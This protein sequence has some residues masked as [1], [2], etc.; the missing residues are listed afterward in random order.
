MTTSPAPPDRRWFERSIIAAMVIAGFA[1]GSLGLT[2][3]AELLGDD[4][5]LTD[6]FN[7]PVADDEAD[8]VVAVTVTTTSP[9]TTTTSPP[10][11]DEPDDDGE[12]RQGRR[13]GEDDR[14]DRREG[15]DRHNAASV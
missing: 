13:G 2:M 1:I 11:V 14:P 5:V 15:R 4:P 6:E 7:A 3:A 12:E 10:V 8:A 9:P